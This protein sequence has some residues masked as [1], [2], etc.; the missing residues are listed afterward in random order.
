MAITNSRQGLNA[1]EK[2]V[3]QESSELIRD[4]GFNQSIVANNELMNK[5]NA[6]KYKKFFLQLIVNK[7][8]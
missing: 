3:S 4:P 6:K 8:W 2:T 1:K 7:S 5:K